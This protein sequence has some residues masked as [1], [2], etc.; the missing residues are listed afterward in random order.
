MDDSSCHRQQYQRKLMEGIYVMLNKTYL[1][2]LVTLHGFVKQV[3][4]DLSVCHSLRLPVCVCL[5]IH[6]SY[7]VPT[8]IYSVCLHICL[9]VCLSVPVFLSLSIYLSLS[10]YLSINLS[11][12][13]S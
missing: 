9:S 4:I 11:V 6:P 12:C 3:S 8:C 7:T 13:L 2:F 10:V 1:E 5:S